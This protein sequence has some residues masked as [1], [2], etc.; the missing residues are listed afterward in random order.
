MNET[1]K[2]FTEKNC[3][4]LSDLCDDPW[5]TH[6]KGVGK[7]NVIHFLWGF[8]EIPT[9][10]LI[11]SEI[12]N[13]LTIDWCNLLKNEESGSITF[14]KKPTNVMGISFQY[15][16]DKIFTQIIIVIDYLFQLRLFDDKKDTGKID[17]ISA[18]D[19]YEFPMSDFTWNLNS[20]TSNND[21]TEW[22]SE[23]ESLGEGEN[24]GSI[25]FKVRTFITFS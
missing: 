15:V 17:H 7:D 16:S 21:K 14:D 3:A 6:G 10:L 25:I 2:S 11:S 13:E 19:Q 1:C 9:F 20:I 8:K 4:S 22:V 24:N 18:E 5:I 23:F 12:D